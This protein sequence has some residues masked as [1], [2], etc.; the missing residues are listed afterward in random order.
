MLIWFL[1][2]L[3][4]P[5]PNCVRI[6]VN[7]AA[8]P[9]GMN[10]TCTRVRFYR[11]DIISM[12]APDAP[13]KV[14]E[15]EIWW[16]DQWDPLQYGRDFDFKKPFLSSFGN[17]SCRFRAWLWSINRVKTANTPIIPVKIKTVICP[18]SFLDQKTFI[19]PTG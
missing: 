8:W 2:K 1:S 13:F 19:I 9:S 10:T 18:R 3:Q 15:Q 5:T 11:K 4:T 7:S 17:S 16:S 14:Y 12:Y 6:A